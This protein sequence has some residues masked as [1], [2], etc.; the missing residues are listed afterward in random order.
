M[1]NKPMAMSNN[2]SLSRSLTCLHFFLQQRQRAAVALEHDIQTDLIIRERMNTDLEQELDAM[3][4]I[5]A[6][7]VDSMTKRNQ[8][9]LSVDLC[10]TFLDK[11]STGRH[12][13]H[14]K[15]SI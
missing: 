3:E 10:S 9:T 15:Q 4:K 2:P 5:L 11:N 12:V 8:I 14:E 7:E 6:T 1:S 13:L